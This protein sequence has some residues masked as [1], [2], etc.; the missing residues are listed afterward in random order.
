MGL[1]GLQDQDIPW[2]H[3]MGL[4]ESHSQEI[5]FVVHDPVEYML[6]L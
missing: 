1:V 4:V 6:T 2:V 5:L 3:G